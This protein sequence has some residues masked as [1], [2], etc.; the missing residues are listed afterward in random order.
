VLEQQT[1]QQD[2]NM[3]TTNSTTQNSTTPTVWVL[4]GVSVI[5]DNIPDFLESPTRGLIKITPIDNTLGEMTFMAEDVSVSK[6]LPLK[7][8]NN[9]D[10]GTTSYDNE[11]NEVTGTEET[12]TSTD[13]RLTIKFNI[14]IT[15]NGMTRGDFKEKRAGY[16][17]G[18]EQTQ[19][20]V[21]SDMFKKAMPMQFTTINYNIPQGEE[22]AQYE[23]ELTQITES[24][25]S[26]TS[27]DNT[28]KCDELK[29][30]TASGTF[31]KM[32]TESDDEYWARVN[33][34]TTTNSTTVATPST[35]S[36][37][38]TSSTIQIGKWNI[39]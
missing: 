1:V 15:P 39:W 30:K 35:N 29:G 11:G 9:L 22:G 38:S 13:P 5:E 34:G 4:N 3:E 14:Q 20:M 31:C 28:S 19:V 27:I 10:N 33:A 8:I 16:L 24:E 18:Y 2:D 32:T 7:T 25:E 21:T 37:N 12:E 36:T 23:V 6:D 26:S 17:Y